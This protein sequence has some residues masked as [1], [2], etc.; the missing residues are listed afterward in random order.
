MTTF[1]QSETRLR[2]FLRDPEA[3]IWSSADLMA[4]F[5]D[6]QVELAMK[7]GLLVRVE[8]HYYPPRYDY[9]YTYDWE[10]EYMEGTRYQALQM[11][12]PTGDV[13]TYAWEAGYWLSDIQTEDEDWRYTQPWEAYHCEKAESPAVPLHSKFDKMLFI[14]YDENRIDPIDKRELEANDPFYKDR[15]GLVTHYWRP[16]DYSNVIIPYPMP[17]TVVEVEDD[18][19]NTFADDG[20]IISSDEA[21]LDESDTGLVTDVISSQDAF[22][23]IYQAQPF[24]ILTAGDIGDYPDWAVK[25]VEY[26]TLERAFG[27]DT[28]GFIPTLRDYWKQRKDVGVKA[29]QRFNRMTLADRDFR[30]GGECVPSNANRSKLRLPDGYPAV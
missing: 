22:I 26:A 5:N 13:I 3:L 8:N 14:S 19:S 4:Y 23:M 15:V 7:T 25:Y 17:A 24:D 6:A 16:D 12:Q 18:L 9:S 11:N 29:L 27:A 1:A 10:L 30:L 28:D 20:G 2:R 21:V